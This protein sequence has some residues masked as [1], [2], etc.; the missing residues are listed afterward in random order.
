MRYTKRRLELYQGI[1]LK[2]YFHSEDTEGCDFSEIPGSRKKSSWSPDRK[3]ELA[4]EA[5]VA[6]FEREL[7]SHDFDVTYQR[8]LTKDNQTA[9][10]NYVAT[11]TLS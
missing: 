6:L 4:V 3:R 8:T 10:K 7:L 5:Y 11:M 9:V 1:R 2:E